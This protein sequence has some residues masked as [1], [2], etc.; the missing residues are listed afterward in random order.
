[1]VESEV[2]RFRE[3]Q[4]LQEQA[5]YLG[6]YGSA[7]VARHDSIIARME[8]GAERLLQLLQEGKHEEVALLME[9]TSWVL[10][11]INGAGQ[12]DDIKSA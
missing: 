12:H 8:R 11:E 7:A 2:V 5:A 4:A 6:L 9:T 3:L 10:E 1:M